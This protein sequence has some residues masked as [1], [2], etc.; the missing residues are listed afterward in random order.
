MR[1]AFWAGKIPKKSPIETD[2]VSPAT[3]D[4]GAHCL[5]YFVAEIMLLP[6]WNVAEKGASP[7]RA[8]GTLSR[9]AATNAATQ[10]QDLASCDGKRSCLRWT[11]RI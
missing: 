1:A 5:T 9:R 7:S 10:G 8:A 2:T 6:Q 3:T 11:K 4:Q